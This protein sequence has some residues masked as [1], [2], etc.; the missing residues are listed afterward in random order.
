RKSHPAM[1]LD[2]KDRAN[3]PLIVMPTAARAKAAVDKRSGA[4]WRR[5]GLTGSAKRGVVSVACRA[6]SRSV[7]AESADRNSGG[8]SDSE[9]GE[10]AS[11]EMTAFVF[12]GLRGRWTL[13]RPARALPFFFGGTWW[14]GITDAVLSSDIETAP[15]DFGDRARRR[16]CMTS[17]RF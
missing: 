11:A 8:M 3:Q 15:I 6:T 17:R 1:S 12:C 16:C 4:I 9:D 5:D 2:P 13:A 14:R 7:V 10:P